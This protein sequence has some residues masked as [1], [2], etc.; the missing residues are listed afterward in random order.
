[1]NAKRKDFDLISRDVDD[2]PEIT[3]K[4]IAEADLYHGTKRVRR[5]RRVEADQTFESVRLP[6]EVVA[7]WKKTGPDWQSRMAQ[8]LKKALS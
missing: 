8:T 2:P 1:M 7:R 3:E 4:W 6:S 5:G